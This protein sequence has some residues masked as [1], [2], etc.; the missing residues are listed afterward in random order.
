MFRQ[1][2][3]GTHPLTSPGVT[4]PLG[5]PGIE[6]STRSGP[7]VPDGPPGIEP[8]APSPSTTPQA[9]PSGLSQSGGLAVAG[10]A[11][12]RLPA[13]NAAAA[14]PVAAELVI[15]FIT[16]LWTRSPDQANGLVNRGGRTLSTAT[17]GTQGQPGTIARPLSFSMASTIFATPVTLSAINIVVADF[18]V[19]SDS[20]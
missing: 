13:I 16:P 19:I 3:P 17:R 14:Q 2:T 7:A 9:V 11:T 10:T 18:A 15:D 5:P 20:I 1:P 8:V 6:P 4:S 12:A